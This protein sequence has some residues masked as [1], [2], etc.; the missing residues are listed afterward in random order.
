MEPPVTPDRLI[1]FGTDAFSVPALIQLISEHWNLVAIV[2]KPDSRA[3]RG[4]ELT[5]PAVKRLGLASGIPVLQPE[6][7]SDIHNEIKNLKPDAGIVVAYGK[8]IPQRIMDL[9]PKGLINIHPSLLPLYRG[10]SPIEATILNDDTDTGV[11]LMRIDAGMDSGPT[12]T[13]DKLQLD[14]TENRPDLYEKLA[15]M[16]ASLLT[17]KLSGILEGTIVALPQE[18]SKATKTERIQKSA[19]TVVWTKPAVQLEREV[20][21]YLGW[22]GSHGQVAGTDAII[23]SVR[24]APNSGKPGTAYITPAEELAVYTGDGSL[25]ID[26]LKPAGKREMTGPEF[27]A[28]HKL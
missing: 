18:K 25:I 3:G 12:Y 9:F 28:G 2:T 8:I 21:A 26:T 15:E 19:G 14:G 7:L 24:V 1:F 23:T 10:S 20:R 17:A 11:T 13:A 22:P 5:F 6:K 16:G 4:Q 27:L